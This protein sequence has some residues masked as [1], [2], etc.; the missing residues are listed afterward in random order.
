MSVNTVRRLVADDTSPDIH[1]TGPW[2]QDV[3]TQDNTGN[4]GPPFRNTQHKTIAD[5]SFSYA[6]SGTL[7][8]IMGTTQIDNS[9]GVVDPQWSC[10]VDNVQVDTGDPFPFP[11]NNWPLCTARTLSD[12]LH[13]ITVNVTVKAQPFWF[14][15]IQYIPSS[16]VPLDNATILVDIPDPIIRFSPGWTTLAGLT[17]NTTNEAGSTVEIDFIGDSLTWYGLLPQEIA[18]LPQSTAT[19]SIDGQAPVTFPVKNFPNGSATQFLQKLFD[20]PTL[21]PGRHNLLVTH[22]GNHLTTPLYLDQIVIQ[23]ATSSSSSSAPITSG[24]S[25]TSPTSAISGV[26]SSSPAHISNKAV[27]VGA[28]VGGVLGGLALIICLV[29]GVLLLRKRF[30]KGG[31]RTPDSSD[32]PPNG[33]RSVTPFTHPMQQSHTTV[34]PWTP[35]LAGSQVDNQIP[36][37]SGNSTSKTNLQR[38]EASSGQ[39]VFQKSHQQFTASS[40]SQTGV[41]ETAAS[42]TSAPTSSRPLAYG[43]AELAQDLPPVYSPR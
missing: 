37:S 20:T 14:D 42:S 29:I 3:G 35:S 15:Q 13:V 39:R 11:E 18:G 12:G 1:Y 8:S 36:A 17:V 32:L 25:V 16:V 10:F 41:S 4:F 27:P 34:T 40:M 26:S 5:A 24:S 38:S 2:T 28:I 33:T 31:R 22:Q 30:Q 21:S 9:T 7:V 23:N 43:V 19:Y 6:F